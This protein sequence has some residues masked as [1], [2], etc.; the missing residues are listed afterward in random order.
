M[1]WG[2]LQGVGSQQ[3]EGVGFPDL[4]HRGER[5]RAVGQTAEVVYVV[6]A[7]DSPHELLEEVSGLV[8]DGS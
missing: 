2:F 5:T 4:G 8:G 1:R 6:G 3:Q 7:E